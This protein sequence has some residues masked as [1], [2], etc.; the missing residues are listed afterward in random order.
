MALPRIKATYSLDVETVR[1]LEEL[2]RQWGFSKSEALRRASPREARR[3]PERVTE[4]LQALHELQASV[5]SSG[6]DLAQWEREVK[7]ERGLTSEPL[8]S[9]SRSSI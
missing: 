8:D 4:G 6:I 1:V 3:Q 7:S 9:Q 2:A 5:R